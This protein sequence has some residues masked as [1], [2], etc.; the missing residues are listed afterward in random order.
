RVSKNTSASLPCASCGAGDLSSATYDANGNIA[1][2]VDFNGN[3]TNYSYDLSRNLETQRVE[4]LTSTGST[5]TV[6]RTISTQWHAT[7]RLPIQI[8]EPKRITTFAYDD[9]G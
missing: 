9:Q 7:F 8:A 5:T 2:S 1:S 3:R 4:G 6:T